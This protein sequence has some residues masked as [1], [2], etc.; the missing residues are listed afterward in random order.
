MQKQWSKTKKILTII[1][2]ILLIIILSGVGYATYLSSKV[3]RVEIDRSDVTDTGNEL[4]KEAEDVIT[5]ALFGT[6]YSKNAT[7]AADSTMI[8]SI[9]TKTNEI[10]LMSLMRDI[11]LNLPDG[12]KSNLNITIVNGGPSLILKT[13]NYNFNLNVDKFVQV[14]LHNLPKVI[15][16]LGGVKINITNE[17]LNFINST[18]VGMDEKNG[19]STP[20]LLSSGDQILNGTQA[21]A[22]CRIRSTSG[23]DYK[24]TE[25]QR[26]VLESLFNEAKNINP[27]EIPSLVNNILPLV[28]TNL[29]NSEILSISSKVLGM[30]VNNIEQARFPLD[31]DHTT[32]WTD[33]YHMII[34]IPKT[35]EEIHKFIYNK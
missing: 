15:D 7:G 30:G 19:T 33:M 11:Y 2:S 20:K 8:L 13:I 14:N 35:T 10:K 1:T 26:D 22:Y 12:G 5:I 6:D 34:D 16:S 25:R 24:R 4:P 17:E 3:E 32:E 9:N 31:S 27:T 23:R 29:T 21:A 18:I 28:S